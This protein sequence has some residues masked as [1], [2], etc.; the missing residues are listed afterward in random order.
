MP[1]GSSFIKAEKDWNGTTKETKLLDV[2]Y[3]ELITPT[4]AEI[5]ESERL[6]VL[7][8]VLPESSFNSDYIKMF[9]NPFLSDVNF[10]VEG[11]VIHGHRVILASRSEYFASLYS[12]GMTDSKTKEIIITTYS[13]AAFRELIRF[14]Y[15]DECQAGPQLAAELLSAAEY[16]RLNRLKALM[17]LLL[18][19][20]IDIENACLILEIAH[21][22]GAKQLKLASLEFILGHYEIISKTNNFNEMHKDCLSEI[23]QVVQKMKQVKA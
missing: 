1:I 4:Q 17:E 12:S 5:T 21:Y 11:K 19:R 14:I 20:S 22:Y 18:S 10:M 23:L 6:R 8:I 16:Y 7:Q 3:G 9:D 15:T 13:Y 2:R